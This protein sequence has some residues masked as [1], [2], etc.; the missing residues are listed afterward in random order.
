MRARLQAMLQGVETVRPALDS[1]YA[2][3]D[4]A[5]KSRFDAANGRIAASAPSAKS[6]V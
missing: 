6:R 1:F 3:L 2:S 5:Q 4:D